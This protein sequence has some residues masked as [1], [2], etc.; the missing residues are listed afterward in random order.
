MTEIEKTDNEQLILKAAEQE[1]LT[2]GY[3][4]ARTTSIAQKAE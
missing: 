4:G 1:F 3:D 2:K